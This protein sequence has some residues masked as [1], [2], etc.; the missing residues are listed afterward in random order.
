MRKLLLAAALG[1]G[2]STAAIAGHNPTPPEG[3]SNYGQC[4]SALAMEQNDVRKN[5]E[6]YTESQASDINNAT[7][8]RQANGSYRIVF[9]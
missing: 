6:E 4:R 3:Y 1:A 7:C 8:E 9:M 5:P 2:L